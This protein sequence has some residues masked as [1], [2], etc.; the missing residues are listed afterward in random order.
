MSG[1]QTPNL[2]HDDSLKDVIR[3]A[4]TLKI[5]QKKHNKVKVDLANALIST[6]GEFLES[7]LVMGY[8]P[9]GNP[10]VIKYA[11]TI[12]EREALMAMLV[13]VFTREYSEYSEYDVEDED[14]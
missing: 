1:E 14:L 10:V 8:D 2:P 5:K 13:K 4:L 11:G 9:A 12:L 7:Y 3:E 6:L